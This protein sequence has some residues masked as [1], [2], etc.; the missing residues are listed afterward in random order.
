MNII[1]QIRDTGCYNIDVDALCAQNQHFNIEQVLVEFC[2]EVI[3][4][5]NDN[6]KFEVKML[7]QQVNMLEKEAK[8]QPSK[9][10]RRNMI[11]KFE[12]GRTMSKLAPQ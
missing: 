6:L 5:E 10:N 12:K 11:N 9:D 8:V 3:G 7:E 2:D 1:I 4:K